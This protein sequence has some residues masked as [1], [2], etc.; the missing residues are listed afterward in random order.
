RTQIQTTI[1]PAR[2][3]VKKNE[4][5][6]NRKLKA[7]LSKRQLKRWRKYQRKEKEKL[8][9]K[10]PQNTNTPPSNYNRRGMGMGRNRRY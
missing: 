2:D 8:L 7:I 5:A 1:L 4:E 9:P 3:S 10:R 6:L